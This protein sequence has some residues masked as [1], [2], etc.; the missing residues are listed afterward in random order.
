MM[1]HNFSPVLIDFGIIQIRWYSLAYIFGI[2]IGWRYAKIILLKQIEDQKNYLKNFDDLIVYLIIGIIVGGRLGYVLLYNPSFYFENFIEIFKIWNGGMSFHGGLVGVTVAIYIFSSF[3]NLNYKI[4]FD[5]ISCVAPIGIFFGRVANFING[6]LYGV[7]TEK[8]WGVVFPHIDS[9][10]RHPSQIYEA[11]L[12][13]IILFVILNLIIFKKN[14]NPGT[15]AGLFLILYGA[16]RIV[17]EQ[18]REPDEHIGYILNYFSMGSILS[19]IMI[20]L[21]MLFVSKIIINEKR[22]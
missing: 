6:E 16:F 14:F 4:Y 1:I 9:T 13:G 15:T 18:F 8:P 17:S 10:A 20:I 12:E 7:P 5:T 2:L 21:G 11:L 19:I 22:R 3:R